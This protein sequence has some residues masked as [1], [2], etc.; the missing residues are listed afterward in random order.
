MKKK[1]KKI[2]TRGKDGKMGLPRYS[3]WWERDGEIGLNFQ[4]GGS[5]CAI[6]FHS[7]S[8]SL[9]SSFVPRI[10]SRK[11]FILDSEITTLILAWLRRFAAIRSA[12]LRINV[13]EKLQRGCNLN[14]DADA[15][16]RCRNDT[17]VNLA[18]PSRNQIRIYGIIISA[19]LS[20]M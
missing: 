2:K 17:S 16:P 15:H 6:N 9:L 7:K 12:T 11:T 5:A 3:K 13:A 20:L 4:Y 8:L 19:D 1:K 14:Y 10:G 18:P